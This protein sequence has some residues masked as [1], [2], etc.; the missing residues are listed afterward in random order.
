[1]VQVQVP[2]GWLYEFQNKE[3]LLAC[4]GGEAR[5]AADRVIAVV[6]SELAT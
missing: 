1:M 2:A 3:L 6:Q 5:K 4:D